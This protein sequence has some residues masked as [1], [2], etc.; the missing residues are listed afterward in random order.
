[1]VYV[2]IGDFSVLIWPLIPSCAIRKIIGRDV[3]IANCR[4]VSIYLA[5]HCLSKVRSCFCLLDVG[6]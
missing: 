5:G 3:K 4:S 1:M 6:R 2:W